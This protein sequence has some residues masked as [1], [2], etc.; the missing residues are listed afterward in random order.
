MTFTE[1]II[2]LRI[3]IADTDKTEWEDDVL[4]R[5]INRAI[6]RID[7][8]IVKNEL[9]FA[10]LSHEITIVEDTSTYTLPEDF[11]IQY[12]LYRTDTK[13][14]LELVLPNEWERVVSSGDGVWMIIGSELNLNCDIA[15]DATMNLYYFP[16]PQGLTPIVL[17]DTIRYGDKIWDSLLGYAAFLC[18]NI[19]EMDAQIDLQ[20]LGEIEQALLTRYGRNLPKTAGLRSL[21]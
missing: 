6:K 13:T 9:Q 17:T 16:T 21:F 14:K 7:S 10:V 3:E 11:S 4:L 18:K 20:V 5:L 15:A 8:I 19:D 2:D 12:G 1:F